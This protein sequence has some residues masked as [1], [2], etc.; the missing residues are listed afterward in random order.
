MAILRFSLMSSLFPIIGLIGSCILLGSFLLYCRKKKA[1][2]EGISCEFNL[3]KSKWEEIRSRREAIINNYTFEHIRQQIVEL[4]QKHD[5]L[6]NERE[7]KFK[8]LLQNRFQQQLKQHLDC[9]RI[10]TANIEGIGLARIATLQSY[11]VEIAADIDS[12]RLMGI[13]GFGPVSR[14]VEW[15]KD[16]E[17]HF[18]FNS[19]QGVGTTE[20][21]TLDCGIASKRQQIEFELSTKISQLALLSKQINAT[22]Q[23]L[24]DQTYEILPKIPKL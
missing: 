7:Y 17:A 21:A 9:Y 13:R 4:K 19:S 6:Q 1:L 16:C 5:A 3:I 2:V 12:T 24:Q 8:Q 18:V 23:N 14:L 10:A 22:R 20:T 15:R 11:L